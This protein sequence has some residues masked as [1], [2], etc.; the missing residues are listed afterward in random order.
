MSC[1]RRVT[2]IQRAT[3]ALALLAGCAAAPVTAPVTSPGPVF[4]P[5]PNLVLQGVPPI[6]RIFGHMYETLDEPRFVIRDAIA[7]GD[8]VFLSWDFLFRMRRFDRREQCVRGGSQLRF[9]PDGRIAD[10][11]D[12]W[13]VAEE[14]Y[15]KLPVLGALMRWLK[16]RATT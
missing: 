4:P 8:Q 1:A 15:E 12:Y 7:E 3:L 6:Q 16:R 14:L 13:D 11:R 9:A 10:H 5:N 2:R